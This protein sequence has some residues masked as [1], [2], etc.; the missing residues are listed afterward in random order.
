MV[1]IL[2]MMAPSHAVFL[3]YASQDAEAARKI[4]DALRAADIEVFLD[5][6]ELRGGDAWDQKIR[7]QIRDCALFVPLISANTQARTEGY[8]RLEWRLADQRTH[9]MSRNKPF[10]VPVVIDGTPDAGADVPESFLNVQWTRLP[11]GEGAASFCR[12]IALLAAGGEAPSPAVAPVMTSVRRPGRTA[13]VLLATSSAV[14]IAGATCAWWFFEHNNRASSTAHSSE[15]RRLEDQAR[16]LLLESGRATARLETAELLAARALALDPTDATALALASQADTRMVYGAFDRSPERM[17]RARD[18]AAKA[19]NLEPK[20]FEPRLAQAM[21]LVYGLGQPV[22]NNAELDLLRLRV[23][24][25]G[26]YRVLATLGTLRRDQDRVEEAVAL[27]DEAAR[28]PGMGAEGL[29][30]KAWA[31]NRL[32]RY[33]EEERT[34]DRSIALQPFA[35]SLALKVY[36][37]MCWHGDLDGALKTLRKMPAEDQL[38]D[39]GIATAVKLYRWRREPQNVLVVLS[40]VPRDWITWSLWVPKAVLTGD[41]HA[42]LGQAAAAHADWTAA[43]RL[44]DARLV[45]SP[46]DRRLLEWQAYLKAGLRDSAGA[47]DAWR[48]ALELPPP[49]ATLLGIEKVQRFTTADELIGSLEAR[50]ASS[51]GLMTAADLRLNPAWD[52]VRG[53]PRFRALENRLDRDPRFSPSAAAPTA[54]LAQVSTPAIR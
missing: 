10:I 45:A 30:Q 32:Q 5:Q 2:A 31:L 24:R 3:S 47:R 46:N 49:A 50:A 52:A 21:F 28:V 26:E 6:S 25:P 22:S 4:C 7:R 19:I 42:D 20:S 18:R 8:F 13:S 1:D 36:L 39:I 16:G 34:V 14:V 51:R 27:F 33:D 11:G 9:L 12:H 43:L 53:L 29:S 38:D 23:E 44:V 35:G 41:A 54:G 15:T 40:T 48:R 37:Q 17:E